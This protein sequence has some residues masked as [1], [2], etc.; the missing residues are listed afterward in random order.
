MVYFIHTLQKVCLMTRNKQPN[1]QPIRSTMTEFPRSSEKP[2][3]TQGRYGAW[4]VKR[5][6]KFMRTYGLR[7]L[8]MY[9][10][11]MVKAWLRNTKLTNTAII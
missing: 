3:R 6:K 7:R 11:M 5:P 10:S 1:H 2:S 9:T 4:N 8:Q